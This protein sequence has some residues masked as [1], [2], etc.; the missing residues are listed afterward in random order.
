MTYLW[1]ENDM[2]MPYIHTHKERLDQLRCKLNS[3]N[4]H[5][6]AA[7]QCSFK[8]KIYTRSGISEL[9]GAAKKVIPAMFSWY[10]ENEF[11]F[12]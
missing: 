5:N 12:L 10:L 1:W 6:T 8:T 4:E 7:P 3:V 11:E 2:K 9:Q